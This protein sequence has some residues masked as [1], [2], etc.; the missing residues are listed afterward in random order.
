MV[1]VSPLPVVPDIQDF[2]R[3]VEEDA[4]GCFFGYPS[5]I[6]LKIQ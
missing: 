3:A 6:C 2:V 4:A 1:P 5:G